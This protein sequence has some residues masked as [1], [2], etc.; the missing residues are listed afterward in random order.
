MKWC[1]GDI[2][3]AVNSFFVWPITLVTLAHF[4][5]QTKNIKPAHTQEVLKGEKYFNGNMML[6][7]KALTKQAVIVV[8]GGF[9]TMIS[10]DFPHSIFWGAF[11]H[12][13]SL[14]N[15]KMPVPK[16]L[17]TK[18]FQKKWGFGPPQPITL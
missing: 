13:L 3:R 14:I 9:S 5:P 18:T 10:T 8:H 7:E 16:C 12:Q 1:Y 17:G 2:L 15:V 11:T 4:K 6:L